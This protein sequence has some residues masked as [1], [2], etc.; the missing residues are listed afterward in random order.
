MNT[1]RALP[2]RKKTSRMTKRRLALLFTTVFGVGYA[3]VAPGTVGSM[4]GLA[5]AWILLQQTGWSAW[6]LAIAAVVLT[7][8]ASLACGVI[9]RDI[10]SEDPQ[11]IV[12]DEVIGQWLTLAAIRP[13]RPLDWLG[14]LV[15]FRILDVLKPGPIRR[16]EKLP[17]GW[18][19]VADDFAAGACGMMTFALVRV[20]DGTF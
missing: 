4:A 8:I 16:L 2:N 7:P 15:L 13:E 17:N 1:S 12:I 5:A 19:V 3:P 10:G 11:F 6:T 14:A 18:G 20:F 9:E